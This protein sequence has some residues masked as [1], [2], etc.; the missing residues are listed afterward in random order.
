MK[1]ISL[2]CLL[3]TATVSISWGATCVNSLGWKISTKKLEGPT[4]VP[5]NTLIF[6]SNPQGELAL[7]F[8]ATSQFEGQIPPWD[9]WD[10]Y[11]VET[12]WVNKLGLK[13][14]QWKGPSYQCQR[15]DP[16]TIRNDQLILKTESGRITCI[17][18]QL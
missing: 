3:L 7:S 11:H 15:C 2:F 17:R 14:M 10:D 9:L 4:R 8:S 6:V 16:D 12:I 13:S 1:K 18:G 5:G